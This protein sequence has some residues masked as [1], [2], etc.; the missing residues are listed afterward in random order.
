MTYWATIRNLAIKNDAVLKIF[1]C[2]S[3]SLPTLIPSVPSKILCKT[4]MLT[5]LINALICT[6]NAASLGY[7]Q[8]FEAL[9]YWYVFT[10]FVLFLVVI[11]ML[12]FLS[13]PTPQKKFYL[14][15]ASVLSYLLAWPFSWMPM[16]E[17]FIHD[18]FMLFSLQMIC[19]CC[20]LYVMRQ[21]KMISFTVGESLTVS[22]NVT[23]LVPLKTLRHTLPLAGAYLL[24]M[25]SILQCWRHSSWVH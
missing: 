6:A 15:Y 12:F 4:F 7:N 17:L 1:H 23:S 9:E 3:S 14:L 11:S 2:S 21:L 10:P 22:D 20:F 18:M 19:S 13:P 5:W 25:V 24:Y 16:E 8:N